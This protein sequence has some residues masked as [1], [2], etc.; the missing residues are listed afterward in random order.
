[1][2][3]A[4]TPRPAPA[5]VAEARNPGPGKPPGEALEAARRKAQGVGGDVARRI[6]LFDFYDEA[7]NAP[8]RNQA[9]RWKPGA[10]WPMGFLWG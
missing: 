3:A 5:S 6:T 4:E 7:N 2:V 8:A 9:P 10:M 1:M